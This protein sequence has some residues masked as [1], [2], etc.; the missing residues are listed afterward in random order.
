MSLFFFPDEKNVKHLKRFLKRRQPSE[1]VWES[2]KAAQ[3][4]VRVEEAVGEQDWE[5]WESVKTITGQK[6]A[7]RGSSRGSHPRSSFTQQQR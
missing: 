2:M 5:V 6:V 3:R 7:Q 1:E 4:E